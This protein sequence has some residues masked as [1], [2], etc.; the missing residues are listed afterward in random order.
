MW[1]VM[2]TTDAQLI[3]AIANAYKTYCLAGG[4]GKASANESEMM[5]YKAEAVARGL[6]IPD[7]DALS[8]VGVFNGEGAV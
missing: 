2:N 5:R 6:T 7:N 4:H 3:Q 1:N 8:A